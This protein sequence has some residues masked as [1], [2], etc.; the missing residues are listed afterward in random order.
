MW[1]KVNKR[2]VGTQQVYPAG[3]KPWSNTVLYYSFDNDTASTSYDNSWNWYNWTW[4]N[5]LWTY[6]T[7]KVWNATQL[8]NISNKWMLMPTTISFPTTNYT[9]SFFVK[10]TQS[11]SDSAAIFSK[12]YFTGSTWTNPY[13]YLYQQNW[14]IKWDIPYVQDGV[15]NSWSAI[16]DWNWHHVCCVKEWTTY[17]M[18]VDAVLK[19]TQ[20]SSYNIDWW[21][22]SQW[23][24]N[25]WERTNLPWFDWLLDE[26][27]LE[28]NA[29]TQQ[30]IQDYIDKF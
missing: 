22:G 27:I 19:S 3:W 20:T 12:W 24:L 30:Y 29:W 15:Y 21:S 18:Y 14:Y 23:R 2:Y 25:R 8:Q 28:N 4:N 9:I 1:Y 7:W 16:N 13:L 11:T 5:N 10:F 17:K 6:T 26:F